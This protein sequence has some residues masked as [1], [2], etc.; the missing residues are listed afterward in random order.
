MSVKL[1]G[2]KSRL[3]LCAVLSL[4]LVA[5]MFGL[6]LPGDGWTM[7][8]L[9]TPVV[10]VGGYSFFLGAWSAF[11]HRAAGMDTLVALGTGTAYGYSV[12]A[13]IIGRETFFEIAALLVTFILLG[14]L[15][16]DLTR[17]RASS[18]IEKLVGLQA[19][20]ATVARD[21]REVS[22]PLEDVRVGDMVVVKPGEKVAMDGEVTAGASTVDEAMVTGESLPVTKRPGDNVIGSTINKTG[23]FTFRATRVGA[24]T[25]LAHIVELVRRA[26]NSRAPIQKLADRVSAIFVPTVVIIAIVT[27]NVWFVLLGASFVTALLYAVAVVVIACPCALGLATP[28]ALMVGTGRGASLGI[29]IKGGEVLESADNIKYV[30]FDKTGTLTVGKPAVTDVMGAVVGDPANMTAGDSSMTVGDPAGEA[31]V[32]KVAAALEAASEHPLA[33][34]VLERARAEGVEVVKTVSF[35][36]IEGKGVVGELDGQKC[37]VGNRALMA[38]LGV[39]IAGLAAAAAALEAAGKTVM[40]VA[41]AGRAVGLVAVQDVAK[42]SAAEAVAALKARGYEPIMITGDNQAT[43]AA[44]A[45]AVGI[46]RVVAEV[47]P[48][49]KADRVK[50]LQQ[51]DGQ[52]NGQNN[53]QTA[54]GKVA[55][56]G[57]GINDAPALAQADLGIAMGS[58]TDIAMEAGGIVL[59]KSDLRDVPRALTLSHKT[60]AR[61]KL[62]LFWAFIYNLAGIPVAAG[63]LSSFGVTLSP[64]LAGLAMAFSSVSVVTS[65]LLLRY[66][67]I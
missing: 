21:G 42:P 26:Q 53:G 34:A 46:D 40:L 9:A 52:N 61:I 44:I 13:L 12:Y 2:I 23:S 65:S 32:L 22:V 66:S 48:A 31:V 35:Q 29:L 5:T 27:F 57:D 3:I 16:E 55:F 18:A 20:Q 11:R 41:A 24:D 51:G 6:S 50:A 63:V 62:N 4:P 54:G 30:V 47:L 56:V 36:A 60:L 8:A 45:A 38:D 58:G 10:L 59:V 25:L 39:D 33:S 17:N 1:F 28:T 19:K 7:W 43:A 14:K 49:D 37:A 64:A 67:K 15:F